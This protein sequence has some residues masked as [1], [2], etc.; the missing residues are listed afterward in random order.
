[1]P[2]ST[3]STFLMNKEMIKATNVAIGYKVI[4]RQRQQIIEEV[5]KLLLVFFNEKQ[6]KGG[7]LSETLIC[8][9]ALDIYGDLVKRTLGLI[10]KTDYYASR[11]WFEKFLKRSGIHSAPRHDDAESSNKKEAKKLKKEFYD[12]AKA[13]GFIPPQVF[14]GDWQNQQERGRE[15]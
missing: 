4:C 12:V 2:E 1:M 3:I 11:G 5:E 14:N 10:Q 9:K 13:E 7:S 6:L 8:E 15:V